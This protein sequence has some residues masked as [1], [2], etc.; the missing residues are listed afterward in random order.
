MLPVV[1]FVHALYRRSGTSTWENRIWWVLWPA[2]ATAA[3]GDA[4]SY[5]G[6]SLP[7]PAGR[8]LWGA[9][10]GLVLLALLVALIATTAY[11]AISLRVLV[12]P[13]W[14]ALLLLAT[15]P[16]GRATIASITTYVPN[17]SVAPMSLAWAAVGLWLLVTRPQVRA[18]LVVPG[19]DSGVPQATV[20]E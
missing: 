9:G 2:L 14:A 11:A 1:W 20:E 19:N 15:V 18:P 17:A 12:V 13:R 4:M 16:M 5:W 3:L 6:V 10:F 8:S 7:G